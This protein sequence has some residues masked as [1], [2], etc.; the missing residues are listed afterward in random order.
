MA[1]SKATPK[2]ADN[3]DIV[4]HLDPS[5][6][7]ADDNIR[8]SLRDG[9]VERMKASI[10]ERGGVQEPVSVERLDQK[11]NGHAYR[12]LKGFIRHAAVTS[13]NAES[14]GLTL[15]ALVRTTADATDRLKT[16]VAENVARASMSPMDTALTIKRRVDSGVSRIDIRQLFA[17]AGTKKGAK[18][19][20]VSNAWL[21]IHLNMLELPKAIQKDIHIGL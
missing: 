3:P 20:P 14:A 13:L 1:K 6:I 17:R 11:Q 9:D 19:S 4:L 10:I 16:Q 18:V 5:E 2:A 15:P 21:N 8:F 7:L 12:L